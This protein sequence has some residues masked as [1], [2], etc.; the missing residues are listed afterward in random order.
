LRARPAGWPD[1]TCCVGG[2]FNVV[3][4]PSCDQVD[5]HDLDFDLVVAPIPPRRPFDFVDA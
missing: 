1:P 2:H 4:D 3:T 5:G